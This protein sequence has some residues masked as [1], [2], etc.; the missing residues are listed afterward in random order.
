MLVYVKKNNIGQYI[1]SNQN[2][3]TLKYWYQYQ[4][5]KSS[6]GWAIL[7]SVCLYKMRFLH[8]FTYRGAF[9]KEQQKKHSACSH[10]SYS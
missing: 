8:Y 10:H 4:P 3:L 9:C 7:L 2:F 5:K 6:I 1:V